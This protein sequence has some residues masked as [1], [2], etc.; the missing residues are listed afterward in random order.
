MNMAQPAR[1]GIFAFSDAK[2]KESR[3]QQASS[4]RPTAAKG[5]LDLLY[6]VQLGDTL[7]SAT[8]S[9]CKRIL[10]AAA[11]GCVVLVDTT[12]GSMI[13]RSD[14]MGEDPPNVI[15]WSS[16]SAWLVCCSDD[17]IARVISADKGTVVLEHVVAKDPDHGKRQRCVPSDHAIFI[18][19]TSFAAAAGSLIHVCEVPGGKLSHTLSTDAPVHALC[20]SP[21]SLAVHW[22]YA[23][24]FKGGVVLVSLS[25][26]RISHLSSCGHLHSLAVTDQWLAAC[27]LEGTIELWDV[28]KRATTMRPSEAEKTVR[29]FCGSDGV[30]LDWSADGGGLAM[31]GKRVAVIDFTGENHKTTQHYI[32][33]YYTILLEYK[34]VAVID[35]TGGNPPHPYRTIL[36]NT[37]QYNTIQYNSILHNT[38]QNKT[39]QYNAMQYNTILHC[40][41]LLYYTHTILYPHYAILY[42]YYTR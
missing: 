3:L 30:A 24:A 33:L 23:A 27:T 7:E 36:R 21:P 39:I 29:P 34:R 31:S 11:D 40:A 37:I 25:G 12:D 42:V 5:G 18:D 10:A 1:R 19:A 14:T 26:D 28:A 22:A 38:I 41:I 6:H 17:G 16:D 13:R 4:T 9:S 20:R 35:S 8:A 15:A 2:A 32:M